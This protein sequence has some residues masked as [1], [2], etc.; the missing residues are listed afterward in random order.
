MGH[1]YPRHCKKVVRHTSRAELPLDSCVAERS[2]PKDRWLSPSA[3]ATTRAISSTF[4]ASKRYR[5]GPVLPARRPGRGRVRQ[6]GAKG[7]VDDFLEACAGAAAAPPSPTPARRAA[8]PWG[9]W[10]V[11]PAPA[12]PGAPARAPLPPLSATACAG[13]A[14]VDRDGISDRVSLTWL[15]R[16]RSIR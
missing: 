11:P 1:Y 16:R 10:S 5:A 12:S 2:R 14:R 3:M 6:P 9:S 15:R 13:A 4:A 8:W 7:V